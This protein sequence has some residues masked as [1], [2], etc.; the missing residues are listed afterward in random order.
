[1]ATG[2]D[3]SAI[4]G[5]STVIPRGFPYTAT[6]VQFANQAA[7]LTDGTP[8]D[9][10]VVDPTSLARTLHWQSDWGPSPAR[11]L[12]SLARAPSR[13]LPVIVTSALAHRRMLVLGGVQVPLQQVAVVRAFPLMAQ[14]IPLAIT[15]YRALDAFQARSGAF[16]ALGVV[17]TYALANGPSTLAGQALAALDPAYPAQTIQTFLNDPEVTLATRTFGYMRLIAIACG[18]LALLGLVLY[19]QARQRSQVIAAALARRMGFGPAAQTLSLTLEL[20]CLLGFSGVIGGTVAVAAA[21]PV[22][23]RIDPLPLDPPAPTFVIPTLELVVAAV[24]LLLLAVVAALVT[25]WSA[26]RTDVSEALRVA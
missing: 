24:L 7:S 25:G 18:I 22:V 16:D 9:V 23:H 11:F 14:G 4:V 10:M 3:A 21:I 1:M 5:E 13:P 8:V 12:G 15:S 26:S 2:S 17:T 19:L 20:V 6:L